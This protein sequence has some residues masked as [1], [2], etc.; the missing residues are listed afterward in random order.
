MQKTSETKSSS[1]RSIQSNLSYDKDDKLGEAQDSQKPIELITRG[2]DKDGFETLVIGG[3]QFV[4]G[5]NRR[6]DAE[7]T[8]LAEIVKQ[9]SGHG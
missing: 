4:L 5:Q 1:R 8:Q 9:E 7:I 2:R 3:K 6:M